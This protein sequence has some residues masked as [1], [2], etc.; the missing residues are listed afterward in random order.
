ML[1]TAWLLLATL[2]FCP[3][4]NRARQNPKDDCKIL[5]KKVRG[6]PNSLRPNLK[7]PLLRIFIYSVS[8][9]LAQDSSNLRLKGLHQL[10]SLPSRSAALHRK[11]IPVDLAA[12]NCVAQHDSLLATASNA[13]QTNSSACLRSGASLTLYLPTGWE[14]SGG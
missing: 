6:S 5:V 11:S 12:C 8:H 10:I 7:L 2:E 1:H 4:M 9:S 14:A 3:L 13:R